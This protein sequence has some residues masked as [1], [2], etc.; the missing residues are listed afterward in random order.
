L[1]TQQVSAF[2]DGQQ[3]RALETAA[4]S[5]EPT[6]ENT[7]NPHENPL[8][9][10]IANSSS[11]PSVQE[12]VQE[13][14]ASR[15][16][17]AQVASD[18]TVT[19]SSDCDGD[20][21][22]DQIEIH[23][24]G[25]FVNDVDTDG[26]L[27]SDKSEIQP[28]TVGGQIWYLDP[29]TLDSNG[30]GLADSTECSARIDVRLTT[31]V[32][33]NSYPACPDTDGDGTPDVYDFD[34]DGDGVPD[35]AD[36]A[37]D[38][39]QP[40]T[41]GKFGFALKGYEANRSIFVNVVLRPSDD[42]HLWWAN[43]VLD[44]PAN[45][46]Q[47]Q[48]QR[49]TDDEMSGGG[50]MRLTP[51][52]EV[53]IPYNVANPTRGLP[54][55]DGVNPSSVGKTTP[56]S[57]WVDQERLASYGIVLNGP[58][59]TDG[60]LY[61]YAPM[62]ILED[63][64]GET[65]VGFG[66]T[67]LYEM[68]SGAGGWGANHEMRL[69]W[70]VNGLVDSCDIDA[71]IHNGLPAS[72]ADTYCNDYANW[73]SQ[74]SLLQAYYDD[75]TVTSFTVQ[76]DHGAS[77]LIVAQNASS[78]AYESDLWHLADT[79]HDTYL[80]GETV[81]GQRLTL[82]QLPTHFSAWGIA[83]SALSIQPFSGLH[84]Q[85]ALAEALTGNEVLT[86]LNAAH[87]SPSANDVANLLFVAEETTV[88]AGLATT[89]VTV[90]AGTI[91]VDLSTIA[92]QTTGAVRWSPYVYT[93]GAWTQQDVT[94]YAGQLA[95]DLAPVLS[96]DALINAGLAGAADDAD[97]VSDGA[98][99]LAANYYLTVYAGGVAT[100]EDEVLHLITAPLVDADHVKPAEPV[101][102]IVARLTA[103]VQSRFAE[104]SLANLTIESS[105]S[106][107]Q[108]VANATWANLAASPSAILT[109]MGQLAAG[110]A[111]SSALLALQEMTAPP[112]PQSISG[113]GMLDSM[114]LV[115]TAYSLKFQ[116]GS[117]GANTIPGDV[118]A[119]LYLARF[120][121]AMYE[122]QHAYE[123]AQTI[124]ELR[125]LAYARNAEQFGVGTKEF[126]EAYAIS[127]QSFAKAQN[128]SNW[129]ANQTTVRMAKLGLAFDLA[130]IGYTFT[131]TVISQHV[132]ADS[133]AFNQLAAQA[134]AQVIIAGMSY[135]I[136]VWAAASPGV[137]V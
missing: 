94:S 103:A 3:A 39:F 1:Q 87:P 62:T 104:L 86:A 79:L 45:D 109:A 2:Y 115:F 113:A 7:Y 134:V 57:E 136:T 91:T 125:Q 99:L 102:A 81:N 83:N 117:T 48:V 6:T 44:W 68:V 32:A 29:R 98:A 116:T 18:C 43:N 78:A 77:A 90:T 28:F 106:A 12:A 64:T 101:L 20:G 66:A 132:P 16:N 35:N 137:N 123:A 58:N 4:A 53:A 61:L 22:I 85:T 95:T 120:G 47:G 27:I 80:E 111:S 55:L 73:T 33:P 15:V 110:D 24:L 5:Q 118:R 34:N 131:Y 14:A 46:T 71:A 13:T 26:D 49:V 84:D 96:K 63:K 76:E 19:E 41:D 121:R 114:A 65:P 88:S 107:L 56:L 129:V 21:L 100:V 23:Q 31:Y 70:T 75:F 74:S 67:L 9:V 126:E 128:A 92:A 10:A 17:I 119:S 11:Q 122:L 59:D 133:P 40:V 135:A 93:N 42:R 112:A 37:P 130:L 69:L 97:L 50:D 72:Q 38:N 52:L 105:D 30:D 82:S 89:G 54:V 51:L 60:L 36:S 108:N 127:L 8:Q 25:T 124:Q